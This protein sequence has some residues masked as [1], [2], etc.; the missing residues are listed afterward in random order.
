M[1][2][3]QWVY[4]TKIDNINYFITQIRALEE[5]ICL[6]I[7]KRDMLLKLECYED[8]VKL[9]KQTLSALRKETIDV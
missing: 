5:I 7:P 6:T 3:W 4:Y 2:A 8:V 1:S 9:D